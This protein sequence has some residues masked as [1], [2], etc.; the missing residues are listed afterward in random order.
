MEMLKVC[1]MFNGREMLRGVSVY[2][3]KSLMNMKYSLPIPFK[4]IIIHAYDLS[5]SYKYTRGGVLY[6]LLT[7]YQRGIAFG[8]DRT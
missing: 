1:G 8:K 2:K 5:I 7:T 3:K 4:K 6:Q